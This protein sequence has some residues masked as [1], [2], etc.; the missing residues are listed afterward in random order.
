[1]TGF[2]G[3]AGTIVFFLLILP[4]F[5][6]PP[7]P[8]PTSLL[9]SPRSPPLPLTHPPPHLLASSSASTPR[10]LAVAHGAS[11]INCPVS[12]ALMKV[13]VIPQVDKQ[14]FSCNQNKNIT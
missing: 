13:R 3:S 4:S 7:P 9:I 2:E 10:P 14:G 11:Q 6:T 1:M 12:P 5:Y 8:P